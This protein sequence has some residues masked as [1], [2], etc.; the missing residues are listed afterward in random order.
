[1]KKVKTYGRPGQ[2]SKRKKFNPRKKRNR[3][4]NN[5]WNRYSHAFLAINP[6]CFV[7][8]AIST[9]VDHVIPHKGD[10][11]LFTKL[12]NHMPLCAACHNYSTAKYD[13]YDPPLTDE[14]LKWISENRAVRGLS[15]KI[16]VLPYYG[17][18]G[19]R[20]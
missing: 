20:R 17:K 10:E 7:C 8:N 18:R 16:K 3:L 13:R 12:D 11:K 19:G 9:V 6:K 2:N 1:M 14:K 5:T 4:Y 15:N